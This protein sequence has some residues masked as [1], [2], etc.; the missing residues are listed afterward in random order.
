[1]TSIHTYD[2][3]P[4]DAALAK[5]PPLPI[6]ALMIGV[7]NLLQEAA[8]LPQPRYVSVSEAG[9]HIDLQF[10]ET[11]ASSRALAQWAHRF[12]GV[13]ASQ[14]HDGERGQRTYCT[15]TFD[16]YGLTIEAYAFIPADSASI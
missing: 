11:Q 1:M 12:G 7:Y 9:Q 16:Y 14:P 13:I 6:A 4:I 8:N 5:M 15:A 3:A 10:G 2:P